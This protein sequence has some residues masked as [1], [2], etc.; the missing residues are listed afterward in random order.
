MAYVIRRRARDGTRVYTAEYLHRDDTGS[1]WVPNSSARAR[2]YGDLAEAR[3]ALEILTDY[4]PDLY[5]ID[6]TPLEKES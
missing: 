5:L 4:L 1:F 6:C 2:R 3:A